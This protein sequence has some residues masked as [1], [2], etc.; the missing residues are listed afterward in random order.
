MDN[1]NSILRSVTVKSPAFRERFTA[2]RIPGHPWQP[3]FYSSLASLLHVPAAC[4]S[5]VR[6][7][8][9]CHE[10]GYEHCRQTYYGPGRNFRPINRDN[11][12]GMMFQRVFAAE[13]NAAAVQFPG[14]GLAEP[15]VLTPGGAVLSLVFCSGALLECHGCGNQTVHARM[16]D[17]TGAFFL[18]AD[19]HSADA[20]TILCSLETPCFVTVIGKPFLA[21]AG[22]SARCII[23]VLDVR[24]VDRYTRDV[25][26]LRTAETT[27]DRFA[28]V[29]EALRSGKDDPL[30]RALVTTYGLDPA[31][32]RSLA[33]VA[34]EAVAGVQTPSP[35]A[36]SEVDPASIVLAIMKEHGGKTGIP[37]DEIV[38]RAAGR[39]LTPQDVQ[40]A[41]EALCRDDECYQPTRG[42]FRIL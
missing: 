7:T 14:K 24:A 31:R 18:Q 28:M 19:S 41:V 15:A 34:R 20:R 2:S 25:W 32:L 38:K 4:K 42:T 36:Q 35:P 9:F 10:Y 6:N 11:N 39:G 3:S 26:V 33:G 16:A 22:R 23:K 40:A 8:W 13:L 1:P 30:A 12:Q 27:L 5:R 37:L 21:G 29:E 17:P